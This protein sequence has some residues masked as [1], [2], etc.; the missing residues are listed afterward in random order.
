MSQVGA[1]SFGWGTSERPGGAMSHPTLGDDPRLDLIRETTDA[2]CAAG[3]PFETGPA[4]V[5]GEPVE[6]FEDRPRTLREM[7]DTGTGL[8]D[9]E[10][11]VF[12]DGRRVT[13]GDLAGRV[14][15]VM[16]LMAGRH[17]I[18]PG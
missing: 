12:S 13:F 8:G 9:A 2:L 1:P 7:L 14:A 16:D 6:V 18:G 4:I 15:S 5:L 17:G 10:C 3:A 11:Y